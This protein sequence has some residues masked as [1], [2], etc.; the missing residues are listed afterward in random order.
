M[1]DWI[2]RYTYEVARRLPES[3]RAEVKRELSANIY[4]MLPENPTESQIKE[5]LS[6]LGSPVEMAE[7]YRLKPRYLIGPTLY[8]SYIHALKWIVPLIGC[9][10]LVVGSLLGVFRGIEGEEVGIADVFISVFSRGLSLGI[11]GV[12]QSFFWITLGFV[13]AERTGAA[14]SLNTTWSVESLRDVIPEDKKEISLADSIVELVI[15]IVFSIVFLLI[16]LDM[17][18]IGFV[19]KMGDLEVHHLFSPGFI[20]ALISVIVIG[21][22]LETAECIIKIVAR[23]WTPL[24][25]AAVIVDAVAGIALSFFLFVRSQ[26][27][28]PECISFI[29][30]Q[31][32]FEPEYERLLAGFP[33]NPIV[34]TLL[35]VIVIVSLVS[36]ANALYRTFKAI[37]QT[38]VD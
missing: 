22:V 27:L 26:I 8:D 24:V 38:P 30:A 33:E 16:C 6:A 37:K 14:S 5:V 11:A 4:D 3:E 18:P 19:V 31:G 9:V 25:C 28:D 35:I 21:T 2:D 10:L 17:I 34:I 7:K 36:V 32:W 20:S 12:F 1:T 15:T 23:R 29:K 13:I